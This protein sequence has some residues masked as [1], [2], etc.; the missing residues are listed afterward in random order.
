MESVEGEPALEDQ[1]LYIMALFSCD[2]SIDVAKAAAL[3]YVDKDFDKNTEYENLLET[4]RYMHACTN[5]SAHKH[6]DTHS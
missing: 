4:Q 2:I 3:Y 1:L 5:P 6:V